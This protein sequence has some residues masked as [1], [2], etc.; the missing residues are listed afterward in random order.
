MEID[1]D[2]IGMRIHGIRK[3]K[4]LTLEEF[5]K[6]V[7]GAGKST[8]SKWERSLTLPN[9]KRLKLIASLGGL[10]VF[11]FLYGSGI[12]YVFNNIEK[13]LPDKYLALK[14]VIDLG[15]ITYLGKKIEEEILNP[16]DFEGIRR[17]VERE[18]PKVEEKFIE[19]I[20]FRLRRITKHKQSEDEIK[21]KLKEENTIFDAAELDKISF[22]FNNA[23]KLSLK[24]K[25]IYSNRIFDIYTYLDLVVDNDAYYTDTSAHVITEN[26][27]ITNKD[28]LTLDGNKS[29]Y[30]KVLYYRRSRQTL[31]FRLDPSH[32]LIRPSEQNECN[33]I[34]ESSD[35][36]VLFFPE[37]K[38]SFLKKYFV[39][40]KLV[41]IKNEKL[42][43]GHLDKDSIFKT[44]VNSKKISIDLSIENADIHYFPLSAIFY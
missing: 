37:F 28:S 1:R 44:I 25:I 36:L 23:E 24:Q 5:G 34:N 30:K 18:Y 2:S 40:S 13:L 27:L 9:S 19:N 3:E 16:T 32:L 39:N 11:T 15:A 41:I 8:V 33:L 26:Y 42:L 6:L 14:G 10:S 4:G 22:I 38:H 17:I 20:D 12:S 21:N 7:D 31:P 29:I 35:L 43:L